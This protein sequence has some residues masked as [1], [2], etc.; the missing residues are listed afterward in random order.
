MIEMKQIEARPNWRSRVEKGNFN[1]TNWDEGNYFEMDRAQAMAFA[2]F[3]GIE[4]KNLRDQINE[5]FT[6]ER[7][8]KIRGCSLTSAEVFGACARS[9][10]YVEKAMPIRL[11]VAVGDGQY[12]LVGIQAD[13]LGNTLDM[14]RV[15]RSWALHHFEGSEEVYAL[16]YLDEAVERILGR[17]SG[18]DSPKQASGVVVLYDDTSNTAQESAK[19]LIRT[20]STCGLPIIGGKPY[21]ASEFKI[22]F[23]GDGELPYA[24]VKDQPWSDLL[25]GCAGE[26]GGAW[27]QAFQA[28]PSKIIQPAW[29]LVVD[30]LLKHPKR[31]VV[32]DGTTVLHVWVDIYMEDP[33]PLLVASQH[34]RAR[35]TVFHNQKILPVVI[36]N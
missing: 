2:S 24:V 7:K 1:P 27:C 26:E 5:F 33:I 4:L 21:D 18:K 29:T 32:K 34:N 36:E 9:W 3:I 16:T 20:I 17:M 10:A 15:L 31:P 19:E 12:H 30:Q 6:S 8:A 35:K 11:D 28:H 23:L 25:T 22:E 14:T 13:H